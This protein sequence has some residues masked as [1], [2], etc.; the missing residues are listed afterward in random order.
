MS[1]IKMRRKT[2]TVCATCQSPDYTMYGTYPEEG[3][4]KPTFKCNSCGRLWQ[5]GED[6]GKYASLA[7]TKK[8]GKELFAP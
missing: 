6:G 5:Y 7:T 3:L 2:N 8:D 4:T 1:I